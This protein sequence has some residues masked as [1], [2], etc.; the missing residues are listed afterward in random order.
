[1][2]W[3]SCTP[4]GFTVSPGRV[5]D[6]V[7]EFAQFGALP[8]GGVSRLC[9][10]LA[11][12][13]ARDR[14]GELLQ[15]AGAEISVDAIGNQ[16][17]LFRLLDD[18]LSV[19]PPI[20]IGSHLDSQPR[21]GRIDGTMGVMA[22]LEIG[23]LLLAAKHAGHRF[24]RN[25][26]VVNWTNEEGA[27]FR[28]SLLGSGVFAGHYTEAF[29]LACRDDAG[30]T[31]EDA[32]VAIGYRGK[33]KAPPMPEFYVELHAEQG[34]RL[35]A[36]GHQIGLVTRNWGAV[37]LDLV[38]EGEQA[39][40]GP[41]PMAERR[42]ALLAASRA[43]DAVRRLADNTKAVIHTSVGRLVVSPNSSNVVPDRVEFTAEIRSPDDDILM[44]AE[45]TIQLQ[46][47]ELAKS[48]GVVLHR[49]SRSIRLARA[50]PETM[51][52][53]LAGC[54]AALGKQTMSIDTVAGHDALSLIGLCQ[55][56]LV[57]VPSIG[58]IAHNEAEATGDMDIDA[59]TS[60]LLEAAFRLCGD[61]TPGSMGHKT[62][63]PA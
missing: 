31:L 47:D 34:A 51:V 50:M 26:C 17:G 10:S 45:A 5:A 33:D 13:R 62:R 30:E 8:G 29:A 58:G 15:G 36:A 4:E 60:V 14:L 19:A 18:R 44:E 35:E 28:P 16:F 1:M 38:C 57:F 9:A 59:G 49:P 40:T 53:F 37:K 41:T 63:G 43:I 25:F 55:T 24:Q 12:G 61:E 3:T 11:D 56:A 20:M 2:K 7:R 22:A 54:S 52:D 46:L 23:R 27:R 21:G 6:L 39:H 48:T 42:D 32:L